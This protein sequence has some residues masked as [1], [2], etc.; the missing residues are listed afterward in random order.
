[1]AQVL[2]TVV[3]LAVINT[4]SIMGYLDRA[5]SANACDVFKTSGCANE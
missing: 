2:Q 5:E 4:V 3:L 1:M